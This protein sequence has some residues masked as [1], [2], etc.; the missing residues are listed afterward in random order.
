MF[1]EAK[2][3]SLAHSIVYGKN[4]NHSTYHMYYA[5]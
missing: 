2:Y 3:K 5:V 4:I 1:K